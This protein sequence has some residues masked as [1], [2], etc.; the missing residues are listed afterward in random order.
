MFNNKIGVIYS[1]DEC[2]NKGVDGLLELGLD[3]IQLKCWNFDLMTDENAKKVKEI[4]DGK[5]EIT[6]M[7]CGWTGPV[8]WDMI[9]GPFT[10]GIVPPDYR[11]QRVNDLKRG[12]DFAEKIG[13]KYMATHAGFI[14]EHPSYPEYRSIVVALKNIVIYCN[15]KDICFTFETGQETPITLMRLIMDIGYDTGVN[16]DPANLILYGR[17]NPVD[18]IDIYGKYI[19]GVHIKDGDYS[20]DFNKIGAERVVGEGSVNFPVF[21]PKLLKSGYNGDLYIEREISGEQ[22][23]I[24]IKNTIVYIKNLMLD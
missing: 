15:N 18:A 11:M 21:L 23:M 24:D 4:C 8:V 5:I 17:G 6:S 9:D 19:K 7:W 1:L 3:S 12:A 10:L 2:L 22:Q 16:F 13:V 20:T 14:P